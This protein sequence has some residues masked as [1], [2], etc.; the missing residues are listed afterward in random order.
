MCSDSELGLDDSQDLSKSM[1]RSLFWTIMDFDSL[2]ETQSYI[3]RISNKKN[4]KDIEGPRE[5]SLHIC[6]KRAQ[7]G[8]QLHVLN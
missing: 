8:A 1:N 4:M 5:V 3:C 7:N 6:A 2:L